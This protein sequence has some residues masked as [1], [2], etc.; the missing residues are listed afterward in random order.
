MSLHI[1]GHIPQQKAKIYFSLYLIKYSPHQKLLEV[2]FLGLHDIYSLSHVPILSVRP[3]RENLFQRQANTFHVTT[4]CTQHVIWTCPT[5]N[6]KLPS[7]I[8]CL[9]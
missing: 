1:A 2:Q 9:S 8:T 7:V 4:L 6:E 5:Q 3:L